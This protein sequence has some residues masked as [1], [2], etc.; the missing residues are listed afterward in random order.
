MVKLPRRTLKLG[1]TKLT[2]L[3]VI[4]EEISH[5]TKGDVRPNHRAQLASR[6]IAATLT[7]SSGNA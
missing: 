5:L 3:L 6:A 7:V 4:I 1:D 2:L